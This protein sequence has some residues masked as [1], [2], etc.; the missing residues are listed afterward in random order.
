MA[1]VKVDGQSSRRV[2]PTT[3]RS[4]VVKVLKEVLRIK[5]NWQKSTE[6]C[7][8]KTIELNQSHQEM[9]NHKINLETVEAIETLKEVDH[10]HLRK[11]EVGEILEAVIE[12]KEEEGILEAK[13]EILEEE[14]EIKEVEVGIKE[15]EVEATEADLK[16]LEVKAETKEA[17]VET[18]EAAVEMFEGEVDNKEEEIETKA[19]TKEAP[20]S[21]LSQPIRRQNKSQSNSKAEDNQ[22]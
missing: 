10:S 7:H 13:A 4:Q 2:K 6:Y 1:K 21:G 9:E 19:E 5:N 22:T 14:V 17:K 18:K 15:E 12:N 20:V 11:E 8:I 3:I 16:I